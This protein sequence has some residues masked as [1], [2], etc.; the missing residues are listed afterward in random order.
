MAKFDT[1]LAKRRGRKP[2]QEGFHSDGGKPTTAVRRPDWLLVLHHAV[3]ETVYGFAMIELRRHGY[4]LSAG[5]PYRFCTD[6]SSKDCSPPQGSGLAALSAASTGRRKTGGRRWSRSRQRC[7]SCLANC[8]KTMVEHRHADDG[9]AN[10]CFQYT[11]A[12]LI[13]SGSFSRRSCSV[14][15][16]RNPE[17]VLSGCSRGR[18]LRQHRHPLSPCDGTIRGRDRNHL[19]RS[20]HCRL[21]HEARGDPAHHH[22]DRGHYLDQAVD[23]AW[24]RFLDCSSTN[25]PRYGFWSMPISA[26]CWAHSIC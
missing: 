10:R 16:R 2:A 13:H 4:E 24:P 19:R 1:A 7:E 9:L 22:H 15:P 11:R 23:P 8:L 17:A 20:H 26:C 14:F 3:K 21:V 6:L 25:L 12:G 18:P 5:T